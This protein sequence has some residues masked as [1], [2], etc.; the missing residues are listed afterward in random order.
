MVRCDFT[1]GMMKAAQVLIPPTSYTCLQCNGRIRGRALKC[2]SCD[3]P[4]NR[5]MASLPANKIRSL[6]SVAS[7]LLYSFG[8]AC[9]ESVAKTRLTASSAL[10]LLDQLEILRQAFFACGWGEFSFSSLT[11]D[12]LDDCHVICHVRESFESTDRLGSSLDSGCPTCSTC[13][14]I[15][16]GFCSLIFD[17]R[18][19]CVETEC[20][21][22]GSS[23]EAGLCS[24]VCSFPSTI[25]PRVK[26]YLAAIRQENY[27][28]DLVGGLGVGVFDPTSL[29]APTTPG[30][31]QSKSQFIR[32]NF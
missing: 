2:P 27:L 14:G 16:A 20:S 9:G 7:S 21:G 6:Q 3:A 23:L 18:C 15:I 26:M 22:S 24:F 11:A 31:S 29:E 10:S 25:V 30:S 28:D 4:F 32:D 19:A 5:R 8:L 1:V 17:Q 12:S 13:S